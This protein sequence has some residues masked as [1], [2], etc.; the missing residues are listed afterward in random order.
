MYT[1]ELFDW[2]DSGKKLRLIRN[3]QEFTGYL[4]IYEGYNGIDEY[5]DCYVDIDGVEFPLYSF[6]GWKIYD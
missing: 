3:N 1:D 6:C 4:V 5:P 2:S